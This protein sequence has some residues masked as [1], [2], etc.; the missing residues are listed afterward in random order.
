MNTEEFINEMN[1]LRREYDFCISEDSDLWSAMTGFIF[2]RNEES[3][4]GFSHI[5]GVRYNND[6]TGLEGD[7]LGVLN[8]M[9]E[10]VTKEYS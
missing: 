3:E 5:T 4:Q 6:G 7:F 9:K 10:A 8:I 2:Y 1:E